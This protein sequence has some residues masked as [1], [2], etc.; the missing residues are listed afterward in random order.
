MRI[1]RVH[2]ATLATSYKSEKISALKDIDNELAIDDP[3]GVCVKLH[4]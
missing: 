4:C 2:A 1:L 3:S